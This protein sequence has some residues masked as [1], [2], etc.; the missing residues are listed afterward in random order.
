MPITVNEGGTLYT[1]DTVYANEG[2]TICELDTVHAN[3]GGT[4]QEIF[5][6]WS[7]PDD[8]SGTY[9]QPGS[10]TSTTSSDTTNHTS[11]AIS[12]IVLTSTTVVTLTVSNISVSKYGSLRIANLSV[13]G[14]DNDNTSVASY[15][16]VV[17]GI[18]TKGEEEHN[19][20]PSTLSAGT[21]T[22]KAQC[23][24]VDGSN[25]YYYYPGSFNYAIKF[26]KP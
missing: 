21:Y 19:N 3:E 11:T 4:L 6:A 26:S 2:G 8:I 13:Y 5:S 12:T 20:T 1:L 23:Y 22:I 18:S 17:N 7:A 16:N 25:P 24:G 14:S 15:S 9:T 10:I